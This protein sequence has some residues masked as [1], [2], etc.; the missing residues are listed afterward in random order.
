MDS[1]GGGRKNRREARRA[2]LSLEY[3]NP[4]HGIKPSLPGFLVRRAVYIDYTIFSLRCAGSHPK[5]LAGTAPPA[6]SASLSPANRYTVQS[7]MG[8][9]PID[10]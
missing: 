6:S 9:A 10:R 4:L 5:N 7:A 1:C 3:E 8:T 2:S